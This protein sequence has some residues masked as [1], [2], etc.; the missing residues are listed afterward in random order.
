[1][2]VLA[3]LKVLSSAGSAVDRLKQ[4]LAQQR[5]KRPPS[6]DVEPFERQLH[7][8]F[9]AAECEVLA[10][11]LARW[12]IDLPRLEVDGERYRRVLRSEATYLSAAGPGRVERSL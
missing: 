9:M 4:F 1:M 5:V 6:E 8:Y 2:T 11:E 12:D 7:E 10:A 3:E